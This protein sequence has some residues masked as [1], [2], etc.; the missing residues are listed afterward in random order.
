MASSSLTSQ[1]PST[2]QFLPE[3]SRPIKGWICCTGKYRNKVVSRI[4]ERC[5]RFDKEAMKTINIDLPQHSLE[6]GDASPA[7]ACSRC[8]AVIQQVRE[9]MDPATGH[10]VRMF[11][12]GDC[13]Q[14]S[15]DD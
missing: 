4:D 2:R 8:L 7:P 9:I 11:E 1:H 14:R 13:G 12:C 15:W 6:T 5:A 10:T 3:L